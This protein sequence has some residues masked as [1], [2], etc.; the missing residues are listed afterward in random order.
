MPL[1]SGN[2]PEDSTEGS[3]GIPESV[4][5]QAKLGSYFD[6]TQRVLALLPKVSA[7][8]AF[9]DLIPELEAA[10]QIFK[11]DLVTEMVK[12]FTDLQES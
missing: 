9:A 7:A 4:L 2:G 8:A 5:F 1:S 11:C 12:E 6:K 10:G 3:P